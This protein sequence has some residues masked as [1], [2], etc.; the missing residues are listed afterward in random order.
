MTR[1]SDLCYNNAMTI[2][3]FKENKKT[4]YLAD[5]FIRL[6]TEE[7]S[8]VEMMTSDASM[9]EMA[10]VELVNI[11]N[12]KENIWTQMESILVEEKQEEEFPNEIIMEIRAGVGGDEAALFAELLAKM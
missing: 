8:I 6:E 12:Q 9:K 2:Q 4:T 7:K 3:E 11:R 1:W 10:E 5:E